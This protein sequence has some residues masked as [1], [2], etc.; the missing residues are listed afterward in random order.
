MVIDN[1][2][3]APSD[4]LAELSYTFTRIHKDNNKRQTR[5]KSRNTL[6]VEVLN[7]QR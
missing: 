6:T 5:V 2:G 1:R 4:P 3:T 7:C